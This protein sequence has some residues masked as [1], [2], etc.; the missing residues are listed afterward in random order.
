MTP[1]STPSWPPTPATQAAATPPRAGPRFPTPLTR[2]R[3]GSCSPAA[4]LGPE[5]L[6]AVARGF[7]QPEH[8]DLLA[9]YAGRYLA[10]IEDIWASSSGHQRVQLGAL[11]FP[12]PAASP[13]LLTM[14]ERIPDRRAP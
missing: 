13:E 14:I 6:S 8:G 5:T 2:K 3:P 4:R 12:Y 11:L 1:A 10:T 7:I 9:C